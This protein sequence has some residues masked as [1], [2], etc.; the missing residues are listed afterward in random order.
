MSPKFKKGD[1][2]KTLAGKSGI[3]VSDAYEDYYNNYFY[4]VRLNQIGP[5]PVYEE[6]QFVSEDILILVNLKNYRII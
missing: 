2:I 1:T 3:I 6:F 5:Y 4:N